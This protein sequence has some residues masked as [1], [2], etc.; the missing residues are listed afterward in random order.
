MDPVPTADAPH[1]WSDLRTRWAPNL[2]L[3]SMIG[4]SLS[5]GFI[6]M[7]LI[8]QLFGGGHSHSHGASGG[9]Y[10]E[11]CGV[12]TQIHKNRFRKNFFRQ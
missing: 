1:M 3:H 2:E 5:L 12:L 10:R 8:D 7:L 11:F 6:F 4:V 9:M